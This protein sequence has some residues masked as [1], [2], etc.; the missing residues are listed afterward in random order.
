MFVQ[1]EILES[2]LL[3][4]SFEVHRE[5]IL[6]I[7]TVVTL[8]YLF[9]PIRYRGKVKIRDANVPQ[10]EPSTYLTGPMPALSGFMLRLNCYLSNTRFGVWFLIPNTGRDDLLGL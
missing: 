6:L 1:F 2:S 10:T 9:W 3:G 4:V 5:M 7:V 8:A